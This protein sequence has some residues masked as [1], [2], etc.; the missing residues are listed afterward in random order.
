M[1]SIASCN[2]IKNFEEVFNLKKKFLQKLLIA[3]LLVGGVNFI[4]V[5]FPAN[6]QIISVAYAEVKTVI[7]NGSAGMSF[8][9]NNE[10]ILNMA[11]NAA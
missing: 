3:S 8:G 7:A 2:I 4:P 9:D 5:N 1:F 6:L 11:K 10:N